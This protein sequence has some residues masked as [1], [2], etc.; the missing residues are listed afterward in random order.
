MSFDDL[1]SEAELIPAG[2]DGVVF[3]PYLAGERSPIWNPD[4]K[5]VFYGLGF[6]KT[7][8]HMT[9]AVLEGVAYALEHNLRTA[10]EIGVQVNELYAMGGAANSLLW[11]QIKADVTGKRIVVPSS[12]T[13]TT[14]GA[15]LLAGVGCGVYKNYEEA[16]AQTVKV[17]RVHEPNLRNRT[18]YQRGMEQYLDLYKALENMFL[19][20][21]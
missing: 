20:Y 13:A 16:I 19:K 9:R 11:T 7:R 18:L 17:N 14:L 8:G 3:L 12:D 21:K 15:A 1:V 6:E 2:S 10:A 5:G 4:A